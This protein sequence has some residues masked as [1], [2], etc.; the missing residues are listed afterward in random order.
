M[1]TIEYIPKGNEVPTFKD[2]QYMILKRLLT[3]FKK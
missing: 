1:N 3:E 2:H